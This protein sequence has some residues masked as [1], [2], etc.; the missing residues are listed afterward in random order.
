MGPGEVPG[1]VAVFRR[2]PFPATATAVVDCCTLVCPVGRLDELM[3]RHPR[4]TRNA[5]EIVGSRTEEMLERLGEFAT[6]P[7][8][9]RIARALL[10]LHGQSRHGAGA[11]TVLPM[12]RQDIADMV[13][14]TLYTVSRTLSE[15]ERQGLIISGRQRIVLLDPE[16]LAEIGH[17]GRRP[18]PARPP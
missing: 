11:Q 14:S 8:E 9:R 10:R 15:W 4:I 3:T 1:C 18:P 5:L 2:V 13:G 16:R 12:S 17:A 7:V 6:E